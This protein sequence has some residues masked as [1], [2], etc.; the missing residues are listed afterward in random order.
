M[1][2][3]SKLLGAIRERGMTQDD[4]AGKIKLSS[5]SLRD[6]LKGK[7]QFKADE[8]DKIMDVLALPM[9]DITSY[10]FTR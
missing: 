9:A 7:T 2:D 1:Y 4:L 6:K 5:V 10:F 8:M 3:H